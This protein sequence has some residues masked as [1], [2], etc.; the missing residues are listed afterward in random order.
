ME[1]CHSV[2]RL[3]SSN[4]TRR[5]KGRLHR[6]RVKTEHLAMKQFGT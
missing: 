6:A 1:F 4:E 5:A 3:Y 2:K